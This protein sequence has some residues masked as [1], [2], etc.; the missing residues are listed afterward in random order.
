[1]T[2]NLR[3]I[4]VLLLAA[5]ITACA[6]KNPPPDF[7][8]DHTASFSGL[9][10]YGWFQEP[11][12]QMPGGNSIV[13]GQFVDRHVREAVDAALQKK[14]MRRVDEG[15]D[16]Y[17]GYST[18]PAGVMSQDKWGVYTWWSWSYVG[19]AG[20]KYRKQGTLVLDIRDRQKK[21]V[22]RGARTVMVGTNPEGLA[23][24]IDNAVKLLLSSFPPK[25]GTEAP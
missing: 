10:T 15:A 11:G 22:W 18:N 20:T 21:L 5:A 1:M 4:A 2:R 13:D 12:W 7:A 16:M 24:D 25:P 9:Q 8:Y 23:R 19:Y 6:H 14:G 3:L 17:I